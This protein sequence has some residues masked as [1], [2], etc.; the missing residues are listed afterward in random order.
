MEDFLNLG[1]DFSLNIDPI[2][3]SITC[4]TKICNAL[5]SGDT[6]CHIAN[7]KTES[8]KEV[9]EIDVVAQ[10]YEFLNILELNLP[11][12]EEAEEYELCGRVI[13][14]INKLKEDGK[15]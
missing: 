8:D 6:F 3:F 10:D 2:K 1:D 12:L 11:R 13:K 9:Y 4:C 15:N 5:D 7:T 14:W